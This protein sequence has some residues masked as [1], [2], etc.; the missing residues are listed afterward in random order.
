M[1]NLDY[2]DISLRNYGHYKVYFIH[3]LY[4]GHISQSAYWKKIGHFL[5]KFEPFL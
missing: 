2:R 1:L 4:M 5:G 3:E